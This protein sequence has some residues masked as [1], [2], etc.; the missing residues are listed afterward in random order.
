[1]AKLPG[2]EKID[3]TGALKNVIKDGKV[4]KDAL[5]E[6]IGGL[7][8]GTQ[9]QGAPAPKATAEPDAAPNAKKS[10]KSKEAK[11]KKS[12]KDAQKDAA[13]DAAKQLFDSFLGN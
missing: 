4:D 10:K 13:Q 7:I 6:G 3:K 2:L 1:M 12:K 9:P 11:K 8:G 5:M